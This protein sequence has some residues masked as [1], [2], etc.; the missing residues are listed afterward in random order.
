MT[1]AIIIYCIGVGATATV[2]SI[3]AKDFADNYDEVELRAAVLIVSY[4]AL[5]SLLWPLTWAL[6]L[7]GWAW[8]RARGRIP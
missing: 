5:V 8:D 7:G 4:G 2:F 6:A 3:M 1:I